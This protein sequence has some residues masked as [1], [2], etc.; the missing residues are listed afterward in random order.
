MSRAR[1][2]LRRTMRRL[3]WPGAAGALLLATAMA[4]AWGLRPALAAA[5][6]SLL[7]EAAARLDATLPAAPATAQRDPRDAVRDGWPPASQREASVASLEDLASSSSGVRAFRL[8]PPV[9]EQV[10]PELLRLRLGMQF[11][12]RYADARAL[13]ASVLNTMP[14]ASLDSLVIE[15]PAT[16][17]RALRCHLS[18]SLYFRP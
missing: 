17:D 6:R 9:L 11:S 7:H 5:E 18:W 1:A 16:R 8:A 2:R 15:D 3:G 14:N 13:L 12:A 4:V 10:P